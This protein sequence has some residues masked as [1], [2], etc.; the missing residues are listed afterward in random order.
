MSEHNLPADAYKPSGKMWHFPVGNRA[1]QVAADPSIKGVFVTLVR[2]KP[3]DYQEGEI[4]AT[5]HLD[6]EGNLYTNFLI[7]DDV[8]EALIYAL[9]YALTFPIPEEAPGENTDTV[10]P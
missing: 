8:A 2:P 1:V 4:M 10:L 5:S 6:D 7:S 3:D 9:R